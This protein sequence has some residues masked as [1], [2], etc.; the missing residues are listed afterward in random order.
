MRLSLAPTLRR[1][2]LAAAFL[3][4]AACDRAPPAAAGDPA[5][6]GGPPPVTVAAAIVREVLEV[7]EFA[8]R[9]EATQQVEVRARVNGYLQSIHF[10]PGTEVKAGDLL[11]VIDPKPLQAR[12]AEAEAA[13][14]NTQAQ[15]DLAK[16][17]LERQKQ[18]LPDR[19]TSKREYD[20]AASL[21]ATL[22]AA[23]RANEAAIQ[24]VKVDLG[25]TRITAPID[26]RVGKDERT[27]GN[28]VQGDAPD[29]P[30]LT[31][32]VALDPIYATFEADEG[33]F[34]KYIGAARGKSLKV[35]V[36]LANEQGTP[37]PAELAFI[38]NQ[39]DPASGTVRMRA[40]LPNPDRLFTPGL[41][42]RV[43]LS[44]SSAPRRAVMVADR[45][46]GTDQ[47]K[48]FVL[49]LDDKNLA[50][51]REVKLGRVYDGLRVIEQGLNEGEVIVVNGL[52]RVRPGA[53][54][55]PTKT[56]MLDAVS[57]PPPGAG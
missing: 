21:V 9:I 40:L 24:A 8:G 32:I 30:L 20:A 12:L 11:F 10:K 57:A 52:Q 17:E 26:G 7:D 22:S 41:Y 25:Y 53:P 46:I 14:A 54:V 44:D 38:D 23:R 5:A 19:A 1:L 6:A 56:D 47:N 27:V 16:I 35:E 43:R 31:S 45:A 4:L 28:L 50:Q 34:L 51:Y 55:T 37:H 36:G 33:S 18:M 49:V 42:A 48:R 15:L 3:P 29:S 13:A 39:L 2:A